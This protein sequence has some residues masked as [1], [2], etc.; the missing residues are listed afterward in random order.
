M[1]EK[2]EKKYYIEV[3]F[4]ED[5]PFTIDGCVDLTYNQAKIKLIDIKKKIEDG[6]VEISDDEYLINYKSISCCKIYEE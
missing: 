5:N 3:F 2:K 1:F 6:Y 4:G